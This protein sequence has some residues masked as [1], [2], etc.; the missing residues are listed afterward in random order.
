[1][2][3]RGNGEIAGETKRREYRVKERFRERERCTQRSSRLRDLP[4]HP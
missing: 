1:M 3:E 4:A 2:E